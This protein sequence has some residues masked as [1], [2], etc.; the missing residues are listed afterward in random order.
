MRHIADTLP[1]PKRA[2]AHDVEVKNLV[3]TK[4]GWKATYTGYV[5]I[6]KG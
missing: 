4:D 5:K 1:E 3:R 6:S 2:T